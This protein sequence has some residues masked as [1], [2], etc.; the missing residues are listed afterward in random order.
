[1]NEDEGR[2]ELL[3]EQVQFLKSE[4][5]RLKAELEIE[6]RHWIEDDR[7]LHE[8]CSLITEL[9]DALE[10]QS[11]IPPHAHTDLLQRAREATR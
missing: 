1:M 11:R 7:D 4:I 8:L 6:K 10:G 2:N 5:K 3:R 9:C